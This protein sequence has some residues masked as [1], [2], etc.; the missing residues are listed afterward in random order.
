[1]D[2][3]VQHD[4]LRPTATTRPNQN[5]LAGAQGTI[6]SSDQFTRNMGVT[7]LL[8]WGGS[9]DVGWDNSR[10]NS[11]SSFSTFSPQ[12]RSSFALNYTQPLLRNWKID[13]TRQQVL[14]TRRTA[15]SQT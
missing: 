9:Y 11:N 10:F 6:T 13:N 4:A 12:L 15:K 14:I 2:T 1:M 5:F 7:Q 3:V 8:P